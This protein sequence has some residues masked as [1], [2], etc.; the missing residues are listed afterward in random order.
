V[1]QALPSPGARAG[2]DSRTIEQGRNQFS[3]TIILRLES[4]D[5]HIVRVLQDDVSRNGATRGLIVDV[6]NA[7]G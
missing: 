6:V 3:R 4:N 7:V 2:D 1:R 5:S